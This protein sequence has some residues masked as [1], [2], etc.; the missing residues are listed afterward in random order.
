MA[1]LRT[2]TALE[3]N[4]SS[5]PGQ[6]PTD[7]KVETSRKEN[8]G[9]LFL[10][11]E[12]ALA[13]A[14]GHHHDNEPIY[15]MF[16]P[17]D[18]DNPRNW[19]V[20]RKYYIT[21]FVSLLNVVTCLCVGS[22]SS[23]GD[24]FTST[25]GSSDELNTGALST[26]ILGFALGPLI[27]APLSEYFGRNPV[28]IGSW[29]FLVIFQ[30]PVA[31]AP[32]MATVLVCR[33]IQGFGGSAPLTNTGGTISDLWTRDSSGFAMSIYGI[34]STIGPPLSLVVTGYLA[35]VKGFR[36]LSWALMGI[37]GG[38]WII[39]ILTLPET[40]HT[41]ILDRKVARLNKMLT[42]EGITREILDANVDSKHSLHNLFAINLTRPLRFL[43]T[44]PITFC[45]ALYNGFIFGV[46]F[47]FNEA[48][49]LV[50]GKSHGFN[51]G[52]VGLT[53][54]GICLGS[55]IGGIIYPL[56]ERYYTR[57]VKANDGK[58][59]PEA[60]MWMARG[61][62]IMIP[63]SALLKD[64]KD[65]LILGDTWIVPVIAAVFFGL[66]IY[67]V[68]LSFLSYVVDSYQT[69]SASSLAGVILVRNLVGAGFPLF[70][71]QMYEKL[72]NEWASS[73]LAFLAL[74]LVP[75][76]WIIFYKG[77]ALRLRSPWA[78]E[79]FGSDE[80]TPH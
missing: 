44:E 10:T 59:V 56:Q 71:T 70:S 11:D 42:K 66:G 24:S 60:R 32:N 1:M 7:E 5:V 77:E 33:F 43:F 13:V 48:M 16:A 4:E 50:F 74:V 67:I 47:L 53:F 68:I 63:I 79:H 26:Y 30:I 29:F 78:R 55:V 18:R 38:F 20:A 46:V 51:V 17:N 34:S 23:A 36:I 15:V 69:Y 37:T 21:T 65:F 61:G 9:R 28:Y 22:T 27:L 75:I 39:M 6:L 41:A 40:R 35:W 52:E 54:G 19:G 57:T 8:A 62:A 31:L 80:D 72:G 76:P 14:R 45:A 64:K 49:P 73:L 3:N 58:S 2:P 25:F 12:E